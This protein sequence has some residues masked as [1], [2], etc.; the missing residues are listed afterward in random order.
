[1]QLPST[2]HTSLN[3]P[4]FALYFFPSRH[5]PLK[6]LNVTGDGGC[7][8]IVCCYLVICD[9]RSHVKGTCVLK[10]YYIC[11]MFICESNCVAASQS[12]GRGG[13]VAAIGVES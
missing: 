12:N 3:R 9:L 7:H 2:N 13:T 6:S 1:M 10:T 5:H 8:I 4:S 11:A